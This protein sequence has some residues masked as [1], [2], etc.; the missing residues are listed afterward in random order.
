[1]KEKETEI[2]TSTNL[3]QQKLNKLQ[4]IREPLGI[5]PVPPRKKALVL[6]ALKRIPLFSGFLHSVDGAGNAFSK[7]AMV[8]GNI[9]APVQSASRGFQIG[10]AVLSGIDFIRIPLIY[11]AAYMLGEKPPISLSK[12]ARLL[13]SAALLGLAITALAIPPIAPIIAMTAAVMALGLSVVTLGKH[14]HSIYA[15]KKE[16][17]SINTAIELEEQNLKNI[18]EQAELFERKLT[19]AI[20]SGDEEAAKQLSRHIDKLDQD[21]EAVKKSLQGLHDRRFS[22]EEK[23]K[24]LG[25]MGIVD[26]VVGIG[27]SS[28]VIAGMVL[29]LFFPPAGLGIVAGS[30][31]AGGLYVLG[32]VGIPLLK[33]GWQKITGKNNAAEDKAETPDDD[34]IENEKQELLQ[35][36]K[37]D[38]LESASQLTQTPDLPDNESPLILSST[39]QTELSLEAPNSPAVLKRK[40]EHLHWVGEIEQELDNAIEH[41]NQRDILKI[42]N[43]IA[44][45]LNESPEKMNKDQVSDL[46]EDFDCMDSALNLLKQAKQSI[47]ENKLDITPH[48]IKDFMGFA[49]LKTALE[50]RNFD[51]QPLSEALERQNSGGSEGDQDT[52]QEGMKEEAKNGYH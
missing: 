12:N 26:K 40:L 27:L 9:S 46:L 33:L 21:Y 50:E 10:N 39:L 47:I 8:S 19:A 6:E 4:R 45:H 24:R 3:W 51:F 1:M 52:E 22:R 37:R 48:E 38:Q 31:L 14:L 15:A 32:R 42:F 25:G 13:Y 34:D 16:I 30:A 28:L 41:S 44:V 17:A 23:L 20:D 49:P 29:S 43:Q 11:L 7:L 2:E 18:Q 36:S 5:T 35:E